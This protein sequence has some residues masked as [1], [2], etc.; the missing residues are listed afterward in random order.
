MRFNPLDESEIFNLL[1]EGDYD[2]Q[3]RNA[4]DTT[5]KKTGNEMIKLELIVWSKEG[6]EHVVFDYLLEAMPHKVK[7][8]ADS[9]GIEHKYSAGGYEAS[10]CV[11]RSGKVKIIKEDGQ[12]SF[13]AKNSVK[14]YIPRDKNAPNQEPLEEKKDEFSDEIPF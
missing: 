9:V 2:F 3:V 14:D 5:S 11:N 10:D 13:Q 12:G 1:P 6:K 8:F 4:S 7:H